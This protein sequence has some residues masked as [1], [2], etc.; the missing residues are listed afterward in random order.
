VITLAALAALHA[1][2]GHHLDQPV[3][4]VHVADGVVVGDGGVTV[5]GTVNLS[6]DS[7]YRESVATSTESAL[8]KARTQLAQGAS[9]IDVGAEA[10]GSDAARRGPGEQLELLLP[11]VEQLAGEAVVSVETYEPQVVK[12]VLGA[13]ARMV[14]LTGTGHEEEIL[15]IVADHDASVLM[16]FSQG[17]NVRDS[18]ELPAEGDLVPFLVDHFGPRLERARSLGVDKVV[19]DPGMGF[20]FPN[21]DGVGKARVQTRVLAQALRLRTLGVPAGHALPHSFDLFED[22]FRKAEGFFAVFALLGGAHLLRVHEVPHI[23]TVVRA[24]AELGVS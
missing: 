12:A 7:T 22:E 11:V 21:L 6:R 19:V 4:D 1:E 10:S 17:D 9:I 16:C 20:S 15:G 13:G 14:N 24:M 8:R 2:H 3:A 18:E 23:R 5:M